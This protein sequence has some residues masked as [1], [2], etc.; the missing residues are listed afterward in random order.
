MIGPYKTEVIDRSLNTAAPLRTCPKCQGP[1]EAGSGHCFRCLVAISLTPAPD[2]VAGFDEMDEQLP[3]A[4]GDYLLEA[5]IA[6]GGMGI[7]YRARHIPLDRVVALKMLIGGGFAGREALLRFK[8]EATA[9]AR[10]H[11]PNLVTL[12]EVGEIE[13]LPYLSMEYVDGG[14]LGSLV[15]GTAIAPRQAARWLNAVARGVQ[16][17]HE[18][19]I[20]H[21]D[22]KPSNIIID[23]FNEPKVTDFGLARQE[24]SDQS[25]TVSGQTLGSPGY[26]PP[27]QARGDHQAT[28]PVSDVYSLGA[29]LYHLLTG[30]PPFLGDSIP[31]ILAQ[32]ENADPVA[33]DR[34]NPDVPRDLQTICLKC[35]EKNPQR[36]YPSA[37]QLA[38]ELGRFLA[39][40]PIQARAV[41]GAEKVWRWSRRRPAVALLAFALLATFIGGISGILSQWRRAEAER[42]IASQNATHAARNEYAADLRA[43]SSAIERGDLPEGRRLLARHESSSTNLDL[44]GFEWF[45]LSERARGDELLE[46][47]AHTSTVCAVQIS[48][49]GQWTASSGMDHQMSIRR[50]PS[51]EP[52]ATWDL[53]TVGWFVDFT[54]DGR[55]LLSPY[56]GNR[57][58]LWQISSH[59]PLREFPGR[60]GAIARQKPHLVISSASPWFFDPPGEISV[61]NYETGERMETLPLPGR[62]VSISPDGNLLACGGKKNSVFVWDRA[63][64]KRRF[65]SPTPGVPWT[66]RF[67]PDGRYLASASLDKKL[68]VWDLS[69]SAPRPADV[70]VPEAPAAELF[71]SPARAET[72]LEEGHWLK[73]WSVSFSPDSR[74][75]LSTSSDRSLR[76]W[77]VPGLQPLGVW[78]GHYDEVWCSAF[79]PDGGRMITGGKDARLM[80]WDSSTRRDAP[81]P[82]NQFQGSPVISRDSAKLLTFQEGTNKNWTRLI[83]L[84]SPGSP[85]AEI[86]DYEVYAAFSADGHTVLSFPGWEGKISVRSAEDLGFIRHVSLVGLTH[87]DAIEYHGQGFNADARVYFAI[88][89]NGVVTLWDLES[90]RSLRSFRTSRQKIYRSVLSSDSRWLALCQTFPYE[91]VIYNTFTGEEKVLRG[92]TEYVKGLAFSPD[93]RQLAT[94]A[95]DARIKLWEVEGGREVQTLIGHLQEVSDVAYSPDGKTLASLEG[96][97]QLKLWRLDTFREV[98]SL[99]RP[100]FGWH[101]NF[102]ADGSALVVERRDG[103][104]EILHSSPKSPI[105]LPTEA[106]PR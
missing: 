72:M 47:K 76:L 85:A 75:L 67:S 70:A 77:S 105:A 41:G 17:A 69:G 63:T 78:H 16:H 29:V 51:L 93:A 2:E 82:I 15:R 58:V 43:A 60:L 92:H 66:L 95:V 102:A 6:R 1:L 79:S 49:D 50:F 56:R 19:G 13:G 39:N 54:P 23:P 87:P 8:A 32:V 33:P 24:G 10:L 94:A 38:D 65:E 25:L 97:T 81:R 80:T 74:S 3:K 48:P 84:R 46:V 91:A 37:S 42:E 7:V 71:Q 68:Q 14:D 22:L 52:T 88:Q 101:L 73:V 59:Q 28:G 90:G 34:L 27:E 99:S 36:R 12:Y 45:F 18:H 9:A 61:W 64:G 30:R 26:M 100:E 4:F 21:R 55:R 89:T 35:L 44:R 98:A 103:T 31:A 11:H 62:A 86:Q 57:V 20:L 104:A 53:G 106:A 40:E 5:R 83:P 96:E